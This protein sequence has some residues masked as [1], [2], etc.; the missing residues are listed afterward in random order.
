[1]SAVWTASRS[2]VRR[3]RVQTVVIGLVVLFSTLTVVIALALLA[4]ASAPFQRAFDAQH[5]A[6]AVVTFDRA[7]VAGARL[8]PP[9]IQAAGP[10]DEAV[11]TVP[12]DFLWRAPGPLV[13]VGRADP[14]G[15]VDRLDLLSGRWVTR[16]GE[17][18]VN[19]PP[20]GQGGPDL[21]GA[22]IKATGQPVLTVVGF[23]TSMSGSADAWVT[24]AQ[25]AALLPT[26]TQVLYRFGPAPTGAEVAAGVDRVTAGLPAGAVSATQSYLTLKRAFSALADSYLPFLTVFGGLGLMV[27]V[28][29]V[30]NVVSGAVVAGHR[31]IGVLKALG[32]TARQVVAVYLAMISI[33][34]VV[35]C[36]LG[37]LSGALVA[38]V[39]LKIAF[40]GIHTGTAVIA[41]PARVPV[42]CAVAM[43]ALVVLAALVPAVR[44]G[45]LSAAG[46]ITAGSAPR[47][48][49]GLWLQRRL[50]GTRLPRPVSLG[51][52]QVV[53][54]PGRA[55]LTAVVIV[56]GVATAT[57]STGLT[58]TMVAYAGLNHGPGLIDVV[59]RTPAAS[60]P[61][62]GEQ[63][64]ALPGAD[65][66]TARALVQARL[67]GYPQPVFVNFYRGDTSAADGQI[68][69]GHPAAGPDEVV[70]GPSFL[71]QRGLAVG[72]RITLE[73]AGRRVTARIAGESI[74][75]NAE[76]VDT[77]WA[78]LPLL[79]PGTPV[80]DYTVTLAP[81]ADAQAYARA[82]AAI[83]GLKVDVRGPGN[84]ATT[85][86]VTFSMVFTVLL[87][88]VAAL[89]VFNTVLLT[90]R[91]RRRDLGMLKAIGMTPRQVTVLAAASVT[92]I[93]AAGG[94][95]G[96]PV[97]VVAHR[98]IVDHVGV[99][100][101]PESMKDVWHLPQL[102]GLAVAGVVI[103]VLGALAPARSA[104]RLT[105]GEVLHTE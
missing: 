16:P 37:A 86:I 48:G 91:E 70:A 47:A 59:V 89:G 49:R 69:A 30:G 33:P 62:I 58:S 35:G 64:L 94:L 85:T 7:K 42:A 57:L 54:R 87:A 104:A 73:L 20:G 29:I 72:D 53:T 74:G 12:E 55:A 67:T 88:V 15:P 43:L 96:I 65:R 82:A 50:A 77:T 56:L 83:P 26:A 78:M 68:V 90:T 2:I 76:A 81:G 25:M 40:A 99:V 93:G 84:A 36:A 52:G 41:V 1:M 17:I 21:L 63:L 80:S 66:I 13:V 92:A 45:R 32:F 9:G 22:K 27:S 79:A 3:R 6:H 95:L 39:I 44:A 103:A 46:A 71:T 11:L 19:F 5:G 10:F 100:A 101:F 31:R 8:V 60:D 105:V 61:R 102:A 34:A 23:A 98:L 28:V 51:L 97:G 18:V 4:A 75:G 38:P 24:P 14:A